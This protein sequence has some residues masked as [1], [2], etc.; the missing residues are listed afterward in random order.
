MALFALL[1][2]VDRKVH[3]HAHAVRWYTGRRGT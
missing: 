2:D 1:L 3:D